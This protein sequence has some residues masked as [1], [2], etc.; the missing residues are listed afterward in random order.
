MGL[1]PGPVPGFVSPTSEM[2]TRF[3]ET[4]FPTHTALTP[5]GGGGAAVV[6]LCVCACVTVLLA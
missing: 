2:L 4:H 3:I 5:E 6:A 1:E